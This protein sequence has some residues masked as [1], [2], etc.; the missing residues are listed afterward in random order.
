M[1]GRR[2]RKM[3]YSP[4]SHGRAS[5]AQQRRRGARR[6]LDQCAMAPPREEQPTDC[7]LGPRTTDADGGRR[8]FHYGNHAERDRFLRERDEDAG[9]GGTAHREK[10]DGNS[11]RE[12]GR[13]IPPSFFHINNSDQIANNPIQATVIVRVVQLQFVISSFY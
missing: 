10:Q 2:E 13:A 11:E 3:Q 7:S 9:G 4:F 1:N 5:S 12:G 8:E 6:P